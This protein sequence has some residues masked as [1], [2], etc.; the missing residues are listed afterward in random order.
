MEH[1]SDQVWADFI[2]EIGNSEA[3]EGLKA[4]LANGCAQCT[5]ERDLWS[6]LRRFAENEM[7]YAVPQDAIRMLKLEFANWYS[8]N[9]QQW[10]VAKL[11]FDNL[12]QPMLAGVRSG[13]AAARQLVYEADGL[14]VD[15]RLQKELRSQKICAVGQVLDK[16]VQVSAAKGSVILWTDRGLPVLQTTPNEHGEFE[17]EF[18]NQDQMR[19]S[20][21]MH[22]RS[23]VRISLP[24]L[25]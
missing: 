9:R 21:E 5:A 6:R 12:S 2:R 16:R 13:I 24:E 19:L 17:F 25:K 20:I 8:R 18:E 22:G 11:V 7:N 23:P 3:G 1:F 10:R 4:H 15:L 14:T